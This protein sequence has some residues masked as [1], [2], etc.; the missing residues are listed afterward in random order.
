MTSLASV[1]SPRCGRP[2]PRRTRRMGMDCDDCLEK[3]YQFLDQELGPTER[4]EMARHLEGCDDCGDTVVFQ[5][6]FL[7]V[8]QDCGTSDVAPAELRKRVAERLRRE[9][10]PTTA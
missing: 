3:L 8:I 5:E 1:G 10:P 7:K 6:R 2:G 4:K 9:V